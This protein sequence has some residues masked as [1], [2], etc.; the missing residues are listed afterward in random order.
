[1][2]PGLPLTLSWVVFAVPRKLVA[3]YECARV[4]KSKLN[5]F[6]RINPLSNWRENGE[7]FS[8]PLCIFNED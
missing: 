5:I 6:L 2:S 7:E 1:M 3:D 8:F 4:I